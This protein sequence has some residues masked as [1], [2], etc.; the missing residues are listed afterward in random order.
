VQRQAGLTIQEAAATTGW[1]PRMLRYLERVGLLDSPPRTAGGYRLFGAAEL[2]RLRTLRELLAQ[3][4]I[5]LSDMAF[6]KRLRENSELADAV[7]AWLEARPR[8]PET[9]TSSDWLRYEQE[10]C[11]RL[12]A[13]AAA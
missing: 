10:K 13:A 11:R 3:Y 4:D 5:G 12:L 2:Q 9:V 1:S 8:R 6:A 7:A